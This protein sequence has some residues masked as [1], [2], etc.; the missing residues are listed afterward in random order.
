MH[1]GSG[2]LFGAS[3][4]CALSGGAIKKE[5]C[6]SSTP[7]SNGRGIYFFSLRTPLN[8]PPSI[9]LSMKRPVSVSLLTQRPVLGFWTWLRCLTAPLR[10]PSPTGGFVAI[11]FEL[12]ACSFSGTVRT[13]P[14]PSGLT[15]DWAIR[16]VNLC[17]TLTK[18]KAAVIM[19][20]VN[21]KPEPFFLLFLSRRNRNNHVS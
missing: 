11:I 19:T 7:D 15:S 20:D 10:W 5:C 18:R 6:C 13:C 14:R 4:Q 3:P 12:Y 21:L 17:N 16:F 1:V 2:R 9:L 8:G